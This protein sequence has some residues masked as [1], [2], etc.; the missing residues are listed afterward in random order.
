MSSMSLYYHG[1][2]H[3]CLR[4]NRLLRSMAS[5]PAHEFLLFADDIKLFIRIDTVEDC[6]L[7]QHDL[8]A[9]VLWARG[10]GLE[11]NIP[12]CHT[13]TYTRSNEHVMFTYT[14]NDIALKQPGDCVMDLGITFDRSLTFRTHIEKV[15]CK[16][17]KFLGFVKKISAEFKLSNSLKTLYCS[18]V[19]SILEY[20]I[21]IW[22]PCTFD[23]S[24]QLERVQRK[25]L[26]FAASALRI[27]CVPHE[28]QPVLQSLHLSTLCDRRKQANLMFLSKLL[29]GEVDS[30]ALLYKLNFRVPSFYSRFS[31]PF[32]I[33]FSRCN[34]LKN[35]PIVR[36]MKMANE[37]PLF[38]ST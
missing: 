16:A 4:G 26:K 1:S 17:L 36:M 29:N 8:D 19:R 25:F 34:Y 10:L 30:P 15:T 5:V 6:K 37:D 9:V 3:I 2:V 28:Y 20:G 12:K 7:L 27:E 33:L 22:D 23:G 35:R 21:I 24:N 31:F 11:F 32:Q 13:M 38:L 14:I 18:F